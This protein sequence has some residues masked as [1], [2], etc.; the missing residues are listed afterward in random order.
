MTPE[1]QLLIAA[2]RVRP[3]P[4]AM[5]RIAKLLAG[6]LDW[7]LVLALAA[8]QSVRP[9]VLKHLA[10]FMPAGQRGRLQSECAALSAHNLFLAGELAQV[11]P[12]LTNA[13][14]PALAFKGPVLA[15]Q[16]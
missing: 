8:A 14:I 4:P 7:S 15:Q 5:E 6:P 11:M 9:P 3:S 13:G 10:A 2:A 12:A 1:L 16:L